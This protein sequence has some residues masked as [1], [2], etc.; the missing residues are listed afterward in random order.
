[1]IPNTISDTF[2]PRFDFSHGLD[3]E[4]R[5]KLTPGAGTQVQYRTALWLH[6]HVEVLHRPLSHTD[7]FCYVGTAVKSMIIL[8]DPIL[9]GTILCTY[10]PPRVDS[11]KGQSRVN[12]A[13][14]HRQGLDWWER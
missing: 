13:H 7:L 2:Q 14:W 9:V 1:M 10:F 5:P 6:G 11:S 12:R 3:V 4:I 8:V